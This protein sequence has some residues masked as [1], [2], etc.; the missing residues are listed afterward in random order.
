MVV[1]VVVAGLEPAMRILITCG[2]VLLGGAQRRRVQLGWRERVRRVRWR[3]VPVGVVGAVEVEGWRV[4][5]MAWIWL[6]IF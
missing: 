4:S 5:V 3:R 6:A 2:L 1:V